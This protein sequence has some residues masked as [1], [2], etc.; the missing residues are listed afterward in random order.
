MNREQQVAQ[1]LIKI[2]AVGFRPENPITFKSGIISPVYVDN[3]TFPFHPD[4]WRIVILGFKDII[5]KN[6]ILFDVVAG[7]EA[8]GIPHSSALGFFMHEPSIFVRKKPKEHGTK[9]MIEGGNVEGKKV[10]LIEDLVSTGG[11]SLKSI[12][13]LRA[14]G[15]N[16]DDCLV[17]VSYGFKEAEDAFEKAKVRL[18]SLTSFPVILKEA[19]ALGTLAEKDAEK[20]KEWFA[21]P[22]GWAKK[23]GFE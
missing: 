22:H 5:E 13:A 12:E 10:L 18:H 8:G 20:I 7:V 21:D 2:G 16:A 9:S 6:N 1:A 3:R 14:E 15:A 17:I 4:E 11:S 19:V 23:Y